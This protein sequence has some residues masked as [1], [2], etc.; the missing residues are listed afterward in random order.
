MSA[1]LLSILKI[2]S[3]SWKDQRVITV[4]VSNSAMTTYGGFMV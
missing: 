1:C 3:A 2:G 4:E